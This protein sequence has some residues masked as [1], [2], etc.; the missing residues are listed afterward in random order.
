MTNNAQDNLFKGMKEH[1]GITKGTFPDT[2]RA[3]LI[4]ANGLSSSTLTN[5]DLW[6]LYLETQGYSGTINDM[7]Y[8]WLVGRGYTGTLT[9]MLAAVDMQPMAFSAAT[10]NADGECVLQ[11]IGTGTAT[12]TH[13]G[14]YYSEN[15]EGFHV[16]YEANT[17]A[18]RGG[19]FVRNWLT[20]VVFNNLS[21]MTVTDNGD[22]SYTL[23]A[24]A[25]A[26]T[27]RCG[28]ASGGYTAYTKIG[29]LQVKS[30][31][32]ALAGTVLF[33]LNDENQVDIASKINSSTFTRVSTTAT[34]GTAYKFID[35][36]LSTAGDSV[37]VKEPMFE[38]STWQANKTIPSE[39]VA[40]GVTRTY[41]TTNGNSVT[42]NVVTEGV[43]SRISPEPT[44]VFTPALTNSTPHS[45]AATA[46]TQFGTGT[47]AVD[48]VGIDGAINTASTVDDTDGASYYA[49]RPMTAT[50]GS[51][52]VG[53]AIF[54]LKKDADTSRFP[55]LGING[56]STDLFVDV[57]TST[58]A[59]TTS[60]ANTSAGVRYDA[61]L[62]DDDWWVFCVEHT[63]G[64]AMTNVYTALY[65]AGST[66]FG[67]ASA[68]AT[69][70]C[71]I[72]FAGYYAGNTIEQVMY[73][74]KVR[75]TGAA[76]SIDGSV[77]RFD[78]GNHD[79]TQG[80]WA[81]TFYNGRD[82]ANGEQTILTVNEA[83]TTGLLYEHNGATQLT[84]YDS[85]YAAAV[86]NAGVTA[87]T[88]QKIVVA[89]G[90]NNMRVGVNGTYGAASGAYDG[91]Y[92]VGNY[93]QVGFGRTVPCF[94]KNI[95]FWK[96]S[97]AN[98]VSK[99]TE[100]MA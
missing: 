46:W 52:T 27:A 74:P 88:E 55:I 100:Y 25:N 44:L 67:T 93:I 11:R 45:Y 76:A 63:P 22:G 16:P 31:V 68:A 5:N 21:N 53:T 59:M 87:M 90:S 94:I 47:R 50:L 82:A 13:T 66:V 1:L 15:N 2:E 86:S 20:S 57:N 17:V 71:V 51:H 37:I 23:T 96:L 70:S 30:N 6:K 69:G 33:N 78:T 79:N 83:V 14:T 64:G 29:S 56:G 26:A 89:F 73:A 49:V 84:T 8:T 81:C 12:Y 92:S 41:A 24:A 28:A 39:Y 65:P 77:I 97:Y 43:G 9:D 7:K 48:A 80:L 38:V 32:G 85:T 61:Y 10:I 58:G 98:A 4:S 19:R 3:W 60:D 36:Y 99:G 91:A 18:W 62:T 95:Q 54:M 35:I 72:G 75:T 40:P 34:T 42:A